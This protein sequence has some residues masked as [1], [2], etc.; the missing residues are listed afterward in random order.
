VLLD[1]LFSAASVDK[2]SETKPRKTS[3][4]T[5][6]G[7]PL[8]DFTAK[9]LT[10]KLIDPGKTSG[11]FLFFTNPDAN[12]N[13]FAGGTLYIPSLEEEGTRKTIG[14]F[15]IPLDPALSSAK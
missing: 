6:I 9:D 1:D 7:T 11:G 14:P 12:N 3:K 13:I 10:N 4:K 8:S 2:I 5:Q 15:S